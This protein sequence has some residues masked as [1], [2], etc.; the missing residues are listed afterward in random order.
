MSWDIRLSHISIFT[1]SWRSRRHICNPRHKYFRQGYNSLHHRH[2][3]RHANYLEHLQATGL[4]LNYFAIFVLSLCVCVVTVISFGEG[5]VNITAPN[6]AMV[7]V[8]KSVPPL[9]FSLLLLWS[10]CVGAY[11]LL[12]TIR[13][14]RRSTRVLIRSFFGCACAISSLSLSLSLSL[15]VGRPFVTFVG[16]WDKLP[17]L[18][19]LPWYSELALPCPG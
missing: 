7:K 18:P 13:P 3:S 11:D 14:I 19:S 1:C 12:V 4:Y 16:W 9:L 10:G 2:L 15:W 5:T 6:F 17:W 8:P